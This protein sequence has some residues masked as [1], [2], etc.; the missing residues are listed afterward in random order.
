[1]SPHRERLT[2]FYKKYK[3]RDEV[4]IGAGEEKY[5]PKPTDDETFDT[6]AHSKEETEVA[7][8][9]LDSEDTT[10][11][12]YSKMSGKHEF[13]PG[14]KRMI[15]NSYEYFK[16][17]KEQG[18][19]K[20][21]RTRQLKYNPEKAGDVAQLFDALVMKYGPEPGDSAED[22]NDDDE[23]EEEED[24]GQPKMRH[25]VYCLIGTVPPEYCEYGTMFN[26]CKPWLA[27]TGP[28][29]MPTKYNRTVVELLSRLLTVEEAA[30]RKENGMVTISKSSRKGRKRLTFVRGREDFRGVNIKDAS[31]SMGKKFACSL[32]LPKT[33]QGQQQIQPQGDCVTELLEALPG[34]FDVHEDQIIV[35]DEPTKAGKKGKK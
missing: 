12:D 22:D 17:Q 1:M 6:A 28:D 11:F 14:E 23:S 8:T 34:K 2:R 4:V 25:V 29:L 31:K 24:D 35:I 9:P 30:K 33:D 19:F 26:E 10:D 27:E 32:S 3:T 7:P 13:C 20:G 5:G 15:V 21:I 16:S 18:L